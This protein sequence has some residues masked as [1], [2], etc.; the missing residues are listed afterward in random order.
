MATLNLQ[1]FI[2]TQNAFVKREERVPVFMHA[3]R[4]GYQIPE[5][6]TTLTDNL[7]D[8]MTGIRVYGYEKG[9]KEDGYGERTYHFKDLEEMIN[10]Y[11]SIGLAKTLPDFLSDFKE[12]DGWSYVVMDVD[13]T[14]PNKVNRSVR[15]ADG[16]LAEIAQD[17]ADGKCSGLDCVDWAGVVHRN[18]QLIKIADLHPV[19]K[20]TTKVLS[21]DKTKYIDVEN[22]V[23]GVNSDLYLI[24][25]PEC[26]EKG[27]IVQNEGEEPT[28]QASPYLRSPLG[29]ILMRRS[30]IGEVVTRFP[31]GTALLKSLCPVQFDYAQFD[32]MIAKATL[33]IQDTRIPGVIFKAIATNNQ[34]AVLSTEHFDAQ[35]KT[36]DFILSPEDKLDG[37]AKV[38]KNWLRMTGQHYAFTSIMGEALTLFKAVPQVIAETG[39]RGGADLQFALLRVLDIEFNTRWAII[40]EFEAVLNP[41]GYQSGLSSITAS[42]PV[43]YY[44]HTLNPETK[45]WEKDPVT[46]WIVANTDGRKFFARGE[47]PFKLVNVEELGD[48]AI[49]PLNDIHRRIEDEHEKMKAS[50]K[51]ED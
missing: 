9:R 40:E 24:I 49:K 48:P 21:E 12:E 31:K 15:I 38:Y 44:I 17:I 14:D 19:T 41:N 10:I 11:R 20:V 51:K 26:M 33:A 2:A 7:E 28:L 39:A 13:Q 23:P 35:N 25:T 45:Q 32:A 6:L 29:F 34:Q 36:L 43:P 37:T 18:C 42:N 3:S 47:D 22:T 8:Y 4:L 50:L 5:C 30:R 27:F 46:K 1:P 16:T